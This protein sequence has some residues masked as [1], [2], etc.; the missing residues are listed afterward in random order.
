MGTVVKLRNIEKAFW[1]NP[2]SLESLERNGV[3]RKVLDSVENSIEDEEGM[4]VASVLKDAPYVG[5]VIPVGLLRKNRFADIMEIVAGRSVRTYDGENALENFAFHRR[6]FNGKVKGMVFE[7][8]AKDGKTV[9]L[10]VPAHEVEESFASLFVKLME[11]VQK[12]GKTDE[13]RGLSSL[14]VD[15]VKDEKVLK[16]IDRVFRE[17]V[18]RSVAE[19]EK[20]ASREVAKEMFMWKGKSKVALAGGKIGLAIYAGKLALETI[21]AIKEKASLSRQV[22]ELSQTLGVF[23]APSESR[24]PSPS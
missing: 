4:F 14:P 9:G 6:M 17:N 13:E 11:Y 22:R 5:R 23:V 24:E 8:R 12:F 3:Y 19:V 1:K 18:G 15:R 2:K 10:L 7:K 21:E 16:G 20:V